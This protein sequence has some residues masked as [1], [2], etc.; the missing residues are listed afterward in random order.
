MGN[1]AYFDKNIQKLSLIVPQVAQLVLK[2][3]TNHL[4]FTHTRQ[5]EL[6]LVRQ[7]QGEAQYF[8][9]NYSAKKE[10]ERW[11]SSLDLSSV[12]VLYVYGVGLGYYHDAAR[13]WLRGKA[14]RYLVFLEDDLAVIRRLMET[15][16]GE[17]ILD[18]KQV[19]LHYVKDL[20]IE[21]QK[22]FNWLSW[23][24]I[25]LRIEIT[26]LLHYERSKRSFFE[27]LSLKLYHQTVHES[28]LAN[29]YVYYNELFFN[30]FYS[31]TFALSKAYHGNRLFNQFK[32]TAAIICGAGPS[33]EKN[34]RLLSQ[35][36]DR[37]LIFAGS[38]ALNMLSHWGIEP[39]FGAGIDPNEAQ[40]RRLL[41]MG[42]FELPLFYRNRWNPQALQHYHG[43]ALYLNGC[44]GYSI[45]RW[46]EGQL[47]IPGIEVEEGHNVVNFSL[48]IANHLGCDPIIFVGM[49]LAF[50][51]GMMYAGGQE[52]FSKQKKGDFMDGKGPLTPICRRD[53]FGNEVYTLR[54]WIAES[55]WIS[56]YAKVYPQ[57]TFIN[58]TEGGLGFKGVK[59]L[60]LGE[61]QGRYLK[62]QKDLSSRVTL[63]IMQA[64]LPE[65]TR[66]KILFAM[67]G[68]SK[69]LHR[70]V[71][72]CQKMEKEIGRLSKKVKRKPLEGSLQTDVSK[73]V[74][75]ELI[76]EDG[77]QYILKEI[78]SLRMK[79]LER[80]FYQMQHDT[81]LRS[82]REKNLQHLK[83]NQERV[84]FLKDTAAKNLRV[85]Q[86]ILKDKKARDDLTEEENVS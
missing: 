69:S 29:E 17:D 35:L 16:K 72:L 86:A 21:G 40:Y 1:Q 43:P 38:S 82:Q 47:N 13:G 68:L 84:F 51:N 57:K 7:V 58:A 56:S 45:A 52:I 31:N 50:T 85:L 81:S 2:S 55:D 34:I 71:D 8:H 15:K 83:L 26:S 25:L 14:D 22:V 49:D 54:K 41:A 76:E 30:N 62:K 11:F 37:A 64:S 61:V 67:E 53:I 66:K 18:D 48:D 6:N 42:F 63:E 32:S 12:D 33:L 9:S 28:S 3:P 36:K 79:S 44:G 5:K 24:F 70:C 75:Q 39:H 77:Y 60:S 23:F 80:R 19:Q 4:Q 65:I 27:Q 59:N 78:N 20:E 73:K 74:E 10:A 46:M